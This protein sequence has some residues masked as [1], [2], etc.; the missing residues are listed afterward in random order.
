M[1]QFIEWLEHHMLSCPSK[2]LFHLEC[3]GCGIQRSFI[4]L[5]KGDVFTSLQLYPALLPILATLLYTA[6][7]LKFDFFHGARNIKILQLISGLLI[8]S[9]YIYKIV[10]HKL[11]A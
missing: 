5:L 10:N 1:M 8:L 3:P 4:A 2:Q 9:F 7:H 6:I 11:T